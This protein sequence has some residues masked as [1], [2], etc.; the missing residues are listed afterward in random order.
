MDFDR[1]K[2]SYGVA[3]K[4]YEIGVLLNLKVE[5]LE[6]LYILGLNHD[7]GYQFTDNIYEHNKVGGDILKES[8]Y[9]YWKEVYY[10]GEI[11]CEYESL[12]LDILNSADM[13]IDKYG[14][15]VGYLGRLKDIEERYGYNSEVY[16]KC[17]RLISSLCEKF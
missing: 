6:S 15:D 4:M 3:K 7:V 12:F 11:K 8:E 1:L 5:E 10:H 16:K 2:H 17:K 13:Q 9:I 14:N